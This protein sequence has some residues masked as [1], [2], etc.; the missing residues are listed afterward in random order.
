MKLYQ[1]KI[2]SNDNKR[3]IDKIDFNDFDD[4]ESIIKERKRKYK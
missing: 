2:R 4:L 3:I 1:A